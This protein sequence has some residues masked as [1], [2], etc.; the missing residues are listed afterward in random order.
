MEIILLLKSIFLHGCVIKLYCTRNRDELDGIGL[1]DIITEAK[2]ITI[3]KYNGKG[4]VIIITEE[5]NNN[6]NTETSIK[7][8]AIRKDA[9]GGYEECSTCGANNEDI[10]ISRG[11]NCDFPTPTILLFNCLFNNT[12]EDEIK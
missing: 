5:W 6:S 11:S 7:D 2:A 8:F 4:F 3:E 10:I 12:R 9:V 1:D